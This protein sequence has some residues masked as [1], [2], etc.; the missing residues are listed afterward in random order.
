[1]EKEERKTKNDSYR[2]LD[3]SNFR[4][5]GLF[6]ESATLTL[7]Q[8]LQRETLGGLVFLI[9]PNNSGKSNVLDAL[10]CM[11]GRSLTDDDLCDLYY[12][13]DL[14]PKV[15]IVVRDEQDYYNLDP[16]GDSNNEVEEEDHVNQD[17]LYSTIKEFIKDPDSILTLDNL[18]LKVYNRITSRSVAAVVTSSIKKQF[19]EDVAV[20]KYKIDNKISLT[21]TDVKFFSNFHNNLLLGRLGLHFDEI[22]EMLKNLESVG[23]GDKKESKKPNPVPS[24]KQE[25]E[26]ESIEKFREKF[27]YNLRPNVVQYGQRKISQSDLRSSYGGLNGFFKSILTVL[28]KSPEGLTYNHEI[29]KKRRQSSILSRF[30]DEL[31]KDLKDKVTSRFNK[32]YPSNKDDYVFK[33]KLNDES[34][35][36]EIYRGNTALNLDYQSTGF[37]WFFDFYF[38]FVCNNNLEW[39]DIIIMDEPATNLHVSGQIELRSFLKEFAKENGLTFVISTHS[40]FLIDCDHLDEVRLMQINPNGSVT[41]RDK[42]TGLPE[43]QL[44]QTSEVFKALT[45]GRHMVMD[46]E[47]RLFYVEGITDYNY[48]TAFKLLLG[49]DNVSFLPV[50][51][52]WQDGFIQRL[53]KLD[54]SPVLIVD[55]DGAG[56]DIISKAEGSGVRVISLGDVKSSFKNIEDLFTKEDQRKFG[57]GDKSFNKTSVFKNS[58]FLISESLAPTTR[59]N[60]EELFGYLEVA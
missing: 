17:L 11:N 15:K 38:S 36:F 45:V 46:P 52:L 41:V 55:G 2:R 20:I 33:F 26:T 18:N 60:F 21:D 13:Y 9:G 47:S 3:I 10:S 39:G 27:G 40:P 34:I 50:N 23:N 58:I 43:D 48:L 25:K 1:M 37:R 57:V 30:Q 51:G 8:S 16:I 7:N 5:V 53:M 6:D 31:N 42:F 28:G 22:E 24:R 35:N 44:E 56:K 59:K 32:M 19:D 14:K 49:Y 4:N 54:K 29:S 12:D